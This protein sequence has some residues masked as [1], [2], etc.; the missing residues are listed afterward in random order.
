MKKINEIEIG[1]LYYQ[2]W[3]EEL[4]LCDHGIY[5]QIKKYEAFM[6]L[7]CDYLTPDSRYQKIDILTSQGVKIW[8]YIDVSKKSDIIHRFNTETPD[9]LNSASE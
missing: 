7:T 9:T 3:A 1:K 8:F 2:D 4:T 6:I 5:T